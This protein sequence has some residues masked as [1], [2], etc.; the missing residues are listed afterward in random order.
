MKKPSKALNL[1]LT[2]PTLPTLPITI[3]LHIIISKLYVNSNTLQ[4]ES[5]GRVGGELGERGRVSILG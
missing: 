3:L 1:I 2:L 4:G 5:W